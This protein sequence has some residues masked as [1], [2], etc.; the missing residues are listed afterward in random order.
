MNG[1]P[2]SVNGANRAELLRYW[3]WSGVSQF[4]RSP[5]WRTAQVQGRPVVQQ[6]RD[7]LRHPL[8]AVAALVL[9]V[10]HDRE[11]EA[12]VGGRRGWRRR[13]GS[14]VARAGHV[15]DDT[16]LAPPVGL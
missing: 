8:V 7:A 10:R 3:A 2:A 9:G 14:G 5:L 16:Q 1:R 12:G 6:P 4:C 15:E 13:F 11:R